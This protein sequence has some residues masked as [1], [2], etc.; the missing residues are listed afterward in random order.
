MI[1]FS[2][3]N[4]LFS[5]LIRW[6]T[7]STVSHCAILV[8]NKYIL[9]AN[10]FDGVRVIA[11][12]DFEEIQ[13]VIATYAVQDPER[14]KAMAVYAEVGKLKYGFTDLFFIVLKNVFRLRWNDL[15]DKGLICSEL[16]EIYLKALYPDK[17][18]FK[19]PPTPE[20]LLKWCKNNL[21]ER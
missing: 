19:D 5:K 13:Q 17:I 9:E 2:V 7:K 11:K 20:D 14:V 10:P 3:S 18:S 6:F 16:V 21:E 15:L 1:L 4:T 12:T 8:D